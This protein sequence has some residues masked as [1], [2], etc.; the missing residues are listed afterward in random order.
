V[1]HDS[2]DVVN[3]DWRGLAT[4]GVNTDGGSADCALGGAGCGVYIA[5]AGRIQNGVFFDASPFGAPPTGPATWLGT[6]STNG[7]GTGGLLYRRNRYYDPATGQFTQ[8]DPSGLAG[9]LNL[10]GFAN[11]DPVNARDPFGL[12]PIPATDCP[13][14]IQEGI[15]W[16]YQ[17]TGSE[18]V[19]DL[20]AGA[21]ATIDAIGSAITD[22]GAA[23]PGGGAAAAAGPLFRFGT[24]AETAEG[25]AA[26][27][28][29]A[30]ANGFGH[31]VSTTIRKPSRIAASQADRAAV[32]EH[33]TVR[34]TG[35]NPAHHTV[36]L[37]KPVTQGIADLF[38][39]LFG[40]QQ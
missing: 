9:G 39:R 11:G 7:Q 38:N 28:A 27:A 37:P 2:T 31:G 8:E 26:D 34:Q 33:F 14:F 22:P 10:Y 21:S 3:Y 30:E 12:C 25:L 4:S 35:Q 23:L 1:R 15:N 18:F 29:K 36:D 32:E 16:A 40:R 17:K 19:L 20:L 6:L 24:E 13:N 5:W